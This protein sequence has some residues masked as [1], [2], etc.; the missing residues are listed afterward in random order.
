M[1]PLV[2]DTSVAIAWYLPEAFA[3]AA[4][5]WQKQLLDGRARFVVPSLHFWEMANVLRTY[6]KRREL[7]PSLAEEIYA[8]HL[9]APLTVEEPDRAAVLATA[10]ELDAT[11]YDAVFITLARALD[12]PLLTAERKTK[13]W[14]ARLGSLVVTLP[15]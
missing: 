3:P 15:R 12:V 10:L 5:S 8:L 6:V 14:V 7:T 2:L 1:R 13:A 9:D 11:A 4:R